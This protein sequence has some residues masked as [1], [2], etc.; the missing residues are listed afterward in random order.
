MRNLLSVFLG[1]VLPFAGFSQISRGQA[2]AMPDVALTANQLV[3]GV[4]GTYATLNLGESNKM[5]YGPVAGNGDIGLVLS[6][7]TDEIRFNIGKSDF[8]GVQRGSI[9]PV[10]N[11]RLGVPQLKGATVEVDQNIGPAT[12][13]GKFTANGAELS[14][15]TWV[16][17]TKNL[18]VIELNNTGS[19]PLDFYSKLF[20]G[21]GTS[22]NEAT[23][24]SSDASTWLKV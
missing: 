15:K 10:G 8:W 13:T 7:R 12:L 20:D 14:F 22:G 23:Y 6:G 3:A 19:K 16:A 2:P 11:L 17:A 18:V 4:H 9:A 21:L 5:P 24:S 1:L